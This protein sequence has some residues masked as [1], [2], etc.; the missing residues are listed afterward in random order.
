MPQTITEYIEEHGSI[1]T[2]EKGQAFIDAVCNGEVIFLF[3]DEAD[4][5]MNEYTSPPQPYPPIPGFGGYIIH[6]RSEV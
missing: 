4:I 5:V 3:E 1:D 6:G 2:Q